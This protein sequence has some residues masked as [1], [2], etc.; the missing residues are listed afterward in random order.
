MGKRRAKQTTTTTAENYCEAGEDSDAMLRRTSLLMC[1]SHKL[2]LKGK[3]VQCRQRLGFPSGLPDLFGD[4][5]GPHS[6]A[7]VMGP[8]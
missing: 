2:K 4:H 5:R 7:R 6:R 3:L 8:T 1:T